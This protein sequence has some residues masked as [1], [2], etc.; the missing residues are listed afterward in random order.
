[1]TV[2]TIKARN[3]ETEVEEMRRTAC[4]GFRFVY[5]KKKTVGRNGIA[6]EERCGPHEPKPRQKPKDRRAQSWPRESAQF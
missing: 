3:G 6:K 5:V 1:M 4:H 2:L